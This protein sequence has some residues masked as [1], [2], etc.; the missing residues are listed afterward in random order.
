MESPFFIRLNEIHFD[1]TFER[2]TGA[3]GGAAE[4]LARSVAIGWT[5]SQPTCPLV[6]DAT[7][8]PELYCGT[9]P[10]PSLHTSLIPVLSSCQSVSPVLYCTTLLIHHPNGASKLG[11]MGPLCSR[12]STVAVTVTCSTPEDDWFNFSSLARLMFEGQTLKSKRKI[13]LLL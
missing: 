5:P 9:P 4:R 12:R 3:W 11:Q 1:V 8:D 6:T 2:I 13:L 7:Y 10:P